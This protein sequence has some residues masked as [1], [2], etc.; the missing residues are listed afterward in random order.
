MAA[1]SREAATSLSGGLEDGSGQPL[2]VHGNAK[3]LTRDVGTSR[4]A[5]G[6]CGQVTTVECERFDGEAPP[7]RAYDPPAAD[8]AR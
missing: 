5:Q 6:S 8:L 4:L 1:S 7:V 3:V 2:C